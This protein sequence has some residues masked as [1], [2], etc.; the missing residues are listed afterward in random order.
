MQK[1]N[2]NKG[3]LYWDES[4]RGYN[5]SSSGTKHKLGRW[6]GEKVVNGRRVRMRSTDLTRVTEWLE[7]D[8]GEW[9][10]VDAPCGKP[11]KPEKAKREKLDISILTPIAGTPY[12]ADVDNCCVVNRHGYKMTSHG[13][14]KGRNPRCCLT[15]DGRK[16]SFSTSRLM[17][18][19]IHG[20]SPLLIPDSLVVKHTND[21]SYLLMHRKDCCSQA[22]RASHRKARHDIDSR[23]TFKMHEMQMLQ[24][25]YATNDMTELLT[26]TFHL[27]DKL[28]E[29]IRFDYSMSMRNSKDVAAE[30]VEWF[31]H[32]LGQRSLAVT[33]VYSALKSRA[34]AIILG[35]RKQSNVCNYRHLS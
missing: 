5:S 29:H 34:R 28:A 17:Y 18:A 21:G 16:F 24:R 8:T 10:K 35:R 2:R 11:R 30:A 23:L 12:F 27:T 6:V 4:S 25:Y 15:I 26:Y 32:R 22:G 1:R 7:Q 20:I 3:C 19:A 33:A 31:C 13:D 14:I 9:E